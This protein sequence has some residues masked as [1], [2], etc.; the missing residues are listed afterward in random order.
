MENGL[1]RSGAEARK[2]LRPWSYLPH[3]VF[4]LCGGLNCCWLETDGFEVDSEDRV[5]RDWSHT[6]RED[7]RKAGVRTTVRFHGSDNRLTG[8]KSGSLR[9]ID[10]LCGAGE[11][12]KA[13]SLELRL[14]RSEPVTNAGIFGK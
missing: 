1:E 12:S 9:K 8:L 13:R 14:E 6:G 5:D 3:W 10:G 2:P 7:G 4:T 11:T